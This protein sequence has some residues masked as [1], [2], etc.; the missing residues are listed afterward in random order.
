[1]KLPVFTKFAVVTAAMLFGGILLTGCGDPDPG[2]RLGTPDTRWYNP[3]RLDYTIRTADQLA[4]LAQIVNGGTEG[5]AVDNFARSNNRTATITLSV[6][7]NLSTHYAVGSSFNNG[8]GWVPI[9]REGRP[10]GGVFNGNGN[11]ISGLSINHAELNLAGLF[12]LVQGGKIKNLAIADMDIRANDEV[13]G[14]AGHLMGANAAITNC[15]T[16]GSI[17]GN[18]DVGG[19]VGFFNNGIVS[20]SYSTSAVVGSENV[21]GIAG[22]VSDTLRNSYSTGIVSGNRHVGGIAGKNAGTIISCAAFNPKV[23][24]VG[25]TADNIGRVT[26][27]SIGTLTANIAFGGMEGGPFPVGMDGASNLNGETYD[28]ENIRVGNDFSGRFTNENGWTTDLGALP[29]L[30]GKTVLMP[31]HLRP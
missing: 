12:G 1:M 30:F 14:L 11:T 27:G 8:R 19:I 2:H 7:I 28:A 6:N 26:G 29:G 31:N 24:P 15:F 5:I 9:G 3:G 21:G 10:F 20:G 25:A 4:G 13:G 18:R 22:D 16:T 23:G 17:R